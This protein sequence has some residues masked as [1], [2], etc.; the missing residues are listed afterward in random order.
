MMEWEPTPNV[1]QAN[2]GRTVNRNLGGFPSK[3][4]EDR[5]LLGKR[6]K[7]VNKTELEK[8]R[9]D[10]RCFRCGRDGCRIERCPLA[11]AIRPTT[12]IRSTATQERARVIKADIEEAIYNRV[13]EEEPFSD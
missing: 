3:R 2:A 5:A 6:A 13:I 11:A 12:N 9:A 1:V 8:R 10:G 7:W 4:P